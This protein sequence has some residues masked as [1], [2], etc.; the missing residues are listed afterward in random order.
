MMNVPE[1]APEGRLELTWTNKTQRLLAHEDGSYEWTLPG[2]YRTSEVR[3]LHDV[4]QVGETSQQRSQDNLLIRGDALHALTSLT[5]LPEFAQQYV[6]KVKQVYIDPPFNTGQAFDHYDDAL[7]HSVWLTMMRDRL[8]QIRTLLAADGSVWLHLDDV[9]VHRAR[10]VMDEI[11]GPNNFVATVIWEKVYSP[12]MD[13]KQFSSRHDSILVYSKNK[14]WTP[15]GIEV[16]A[17]RRQF[18]KLDAEGR[19]YRSRQLRKD[20]KGSSRQ[21]RPNMWFGVEAPDGTTA[22]PI[23]SDGS[24]GRWRWGRETYE[25]KKDELEW[26]PTPE[27]LMPYVKQYA[28]ASTTRPPETIWPAHVVGHNH[29]AAEHLKDLLGSSFATPKPERLLERI[30]HIGTNPGDIVLDCFAGSGTTAAVAHKMGRRWATVEWEH[31][32]IEDFTLPRLK[33]VVAGEDPG[34]ITYTES[35]EAVSDLP[36]SVSPEAAR[37]A[38]TVLS[39]LV[40]HGNFTADGMLDRLR[41]LGSFVPKGRNLSDEKMAEKTANAETELW[42]LLLSKL[43]ATGKTRTIRTARWSGG[44][45][46]RVLDIGPSMFEVENKQVL[47]AH[48]AEGDALAEAVAGQYRFTFEVSSPFSGRRGR[49]RLAVIDGLVNDAVVDFL[50]DWLDDGELLMAFGT[51]IDPAAAERLGELSRGSSLRK[52]PESIVSSY[53]RS[54]RKQHE[55]LDWV[56]PSRAELGGMK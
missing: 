45:G 55:G 38:Q 11:F 19:S 40:Q 31:K 26:L 51:S 22:W 46:F 12:R 4:T 41:K 6:G 16:A 25:L 13:A 44:G 1:V 43:G 48:W 20:G 9:E 36:L 42:R 49:Q 24:E 17:D 39:E 30:I 35:V 54:S 52:I 34:G 27:G 50:L 15:N 37:A 7:E 14:G 23:R 18:S 2:D 53:R 29:E 47:L 32:T 3:L 21:D 33:R 10:S 28:D 5:Q 56:A 8:K